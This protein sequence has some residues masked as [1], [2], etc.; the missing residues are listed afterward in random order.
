MNV[1]AA[2][3][4]PVCLVDTVES[5]S[6]TELESIVIVG[7]SLAGLRAAETLRNDGFTGRITM[8]GAESHRPYDR[9]P[10]SKKLLAGEWEPERI[11]LRKPEDLDGLNLDWRLG[12][13]ATGLDTDKRQVLLA[14]GEAVS[15]DGLI[16]ATGC[17][18][19]YLPGQPAWAGIYTLRTLDDS[20]SLRDELRPG[21]KLVVIGAGFIGLE[22]AATATARGAT[23]TVLEG[24]EAPM[25]RGLGSE[26]GRAAAL[27]HGDNGVTLRTSI[28]VDGLIEGEPG[29]VGGVRLKDGEIVP[30]DVVVVGIGVAPATQ[31]LEGSALKLDN[32]VRCDATLNAGV[33][34]IYVAGDVCHWFNDLYGREM[35]VEHWTTAS[36]QGAAAARNLLAESRGEEGKH[37]AAVPFFWSDQFTAR[38]Q[39]LGRAEGDENVHVVF[40]TPEERSFVAL[41]E[42]DGVL[43]AALGVSRP[44]QLM[45]FRTLIAERATWDQAREYVASIQNSAN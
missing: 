15:Y 29:R 13:A 4:P 2:G 39:F 7:S 26:M 34:K 33:P 18:P 1:N 16:I 12:S 41:Y 17:L 44:R 3:T 32:G 8:I 36:E 10:L 42:R 40:G 5:V 11:A 35:R 14:N 24:A 25:M 20:L 31:W 37:Y 9:P 27:V 23:V 21:V 22:V 45:P 38:I 19:R 30:A 28:M 6:V 43:V